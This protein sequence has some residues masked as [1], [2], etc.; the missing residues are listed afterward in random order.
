M[1]IWNSIHCSGCATV[2]TFII[3]SHQ[4]QRKTEFL[5][6]FFCTVGK[7]SLASVSKD[8]LPKAAPQRYSETSLT[9]SPQQQ[10]LLTNTRPSSPSP[11]GRT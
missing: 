1:D 2:G 4:R 7:A 8:K 5:H 3:K 6:S 11:G 10:I 9:E